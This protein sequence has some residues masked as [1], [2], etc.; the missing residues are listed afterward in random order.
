MLQDQYF[1]EM[2]AV[3]E[4][5][6]STQR[7]HIAR[8]AE[9]IASSLV[10]D[11]AWHILDTGHMLMFE[12]IGRSG[13]LMAVQ[14]IKI[15]VEVENP[16][17]RRKRGEGKPKVYYDSIP[18]MAEFVLARSQ[19]LPGDVLLIGSVSGI[20]QLPVGIALEARRQ[21][22]TTIALTS[23]EYSKALEPANPYGSRLCEVCDYVLDNCAPPGDALVAV[24]GIEADICP[25]SGISASY[26]NW[27]LQAQVVEALLKRGKQPSVYLSNHL[28]GAGDYNRRA[29]L[30]Y[31]QQGF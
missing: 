31:E 9:V 18:G 1:Q 16:V 19:V 14:P 13:G 25:A 2:K 24:E 30:Q 10:D 5:V 6:E 21:G 3:L 15:T 26:I 4:R 8:C 23:V 20:N 27:A 11:G 28:P 7:E 22:I 17:R 12:A 29:L